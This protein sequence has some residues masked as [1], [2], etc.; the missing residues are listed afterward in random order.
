M[1]IIQQVTKRLHRKE[2]PTDQ[3]HGPSYNLVQ[4]LV[5]RHNGYST[6]AVCS[7]ICVQEHSGCCQQANG[8]CCYWCAPDNVYKVTFEI[9]GGGG[10]GPGH[11]CCNCCS[12]AIGGAG[13]NY[14]IQTIDTNPGCQYSVCAGG[15]WPCGKSHTCGQRAWVVN[16]MLTVIT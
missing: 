10:G 15:S 3:S 4:V 16:P 12:F 9:W 13:G 14:A 11:T 6:N 1:A 7:A 5:V 8:R 2:Y